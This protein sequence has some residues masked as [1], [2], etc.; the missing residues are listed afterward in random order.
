M[1]QFHSFFVAMLI[2]AL[3]LG[4]CAGTSGVKLPENAEPFPI[5]EF[6]DAVFHP[7]LAESFGNLLL[8][9]SAMDGGYLAL[10]VSGGGQ[11]KFQLEKDGMS[12]HYDLSGD[13]STVILPLNMGNGSYALRLLENAGEGKYACLWS[14]SRDA[15]LDNEFAP[16]LV[17]S[18]LV[19]YS[20]D[21]QCTALARQLAAQCQTDSEVASAIYKYLVKH[22]SYDTEKA[23]SVTTGYLPLPDRTLEEGKGICFDYASLAAAMMRSLGIPCKLIMG[24]VD[25]SIYHAWNSFYLRDQGWVTVEIKAKPGLWQRVDITMAASG[26]PAADLQDDGKY[27]ARYTY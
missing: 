3:V 24:Y 6:R 12:Y 11:F 1:R 25:G 8:D 18:Q 4:G 20:A 23:A 13:G 17:P 16:F 19:S 22:I 7:E 5:P 27:T 14:D 15:S 10:Q 21:S 26:T 2:L 9:A